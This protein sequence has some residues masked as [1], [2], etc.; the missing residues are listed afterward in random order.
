VK[1]ETKERK[2]NLTAIRDIGDIK[3]DLTG[4]SQEPGK[5]TTGDPT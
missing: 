3:C 5:K 4:H 1:M 2:E